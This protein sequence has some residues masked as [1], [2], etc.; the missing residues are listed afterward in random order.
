MGYQSKLWPE[1]DDW[2]RSGRGDDLSSEDRAFYRGRRYQR[3]RTARIVLWCSGGL[4]IVV[5][6][7]NFIQGHIIFVTLR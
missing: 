4:I 6:V 5:A 2:N 7:V 3:R 1:K